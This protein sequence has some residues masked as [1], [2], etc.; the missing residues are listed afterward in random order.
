MSAH[1]TQNSTLVPLGIY[2]QHINLLKAGSWTMESFQSM[3]SWG[4][5][6]T[7]MRLE[8]KFFSK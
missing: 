2:P 1:Y 8:V 3:T 4:N 7:Y 6:Y 5:K